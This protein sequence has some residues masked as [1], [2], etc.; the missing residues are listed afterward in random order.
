M[1]TKH[2]EAGSKV[3]HNFGLVCHLQTAD[4][5]LTHG[6]LFK[7]PGHNIHVPVGISASRNSQ[8]HKLLRRI[9]LLAG[10]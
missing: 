8:S 10:L 3:P 7:C 2:A 9:D 4:A 1:L 5:F 6:N